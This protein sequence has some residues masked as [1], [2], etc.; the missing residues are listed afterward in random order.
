MRVP[1]GNPGLLAGAADGEV[2]G[3]GGVPLACPPLRLPLVSVLLTRL[4]PGLA[5]R[6]HRGPFSF[7]RLSG[8]E[9]VCPCLQSQEWPDDLLCPRP[10]G[11]K[12][13]SALVLG[14]VTLGTIDPNL[15][16]HV[17]VAGA[18]QAD[19]TGPHAGLTLESDHR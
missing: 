18:H 16:R 13:P 2:V 3:A 17:D 8:A 1:M 11:D 9:Q 6:A 4:Y 10:E 14:L 12:A 15:P 5:G 19:F 7:H